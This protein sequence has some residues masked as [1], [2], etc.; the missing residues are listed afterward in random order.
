[1]L[2]KREIVLFVIFL[3][4]ISICAQNISFLGVPLVGNINDF[5][6]QLAMKGTKMNKE[7]SRKLEDGVRAFDVTIFP[8]TCLGR[9]EY[10]TITKNVYEGILMFNISASLSDFTSFMDEFAYKIEDKYNK[11]IFISDR[12]EEEYH[13]YPANHYEIY[14]TRTNKFIGEIYIY[15]DVKRYNKQTQTGDFLL[16][17][18]YRNNEAPNL[19]SQMQDYY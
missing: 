2:R 3:S 1:M 14:S 13:S 9:V 15:M 8:Y 18:M 17:I 5:T 19:D 7:I 4:T 11:G 16:H 10:N 6:E 12:Y